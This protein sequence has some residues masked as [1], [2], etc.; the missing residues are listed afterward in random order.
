MY[1]KKK[2]YFLAKRE[3]VHFCQ[4][5]AD[6]D[7]FE[8][9]YEID[10][11][12]G[13]ELI[14]IPDG[15][16]DIQ[17]LWKNSQLRI[18]VC[19]SVTKAKLSALP[20]FDK[21]FGARFKIGILPEEIRSNLNDIIDNRL[22]LGTIMDI[23]RI[24]A[25]FREELLPEQKADVMLAIFEHQYAGGD[26]YIIREL[27]KEIEAAKGNLNIAEM[28]DSTGYSHRYI[29]YIFKNNVGV[30]VKK[31]AGIIRLQKS[32]EYIL[33][34]EGDLIY[35]E[36]GYYDQAHFIKDFKSFSSITPNAM[37]KQFG[38]LEFI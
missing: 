33:L 20:D 30:S 12:K 2:T 18:Y 6:S 5:A 27:V 26:N 15:S 16:V 23:S 36:L 7:V 14:V 13:T 4:I 32:L 37:K 9:F 21:C 28:I 11:V 31:Y 34:D 38:E 3:N 17:C 1:M 22:E 10:N 25:Y 29:N 19:G 8:F 24:S 35:D